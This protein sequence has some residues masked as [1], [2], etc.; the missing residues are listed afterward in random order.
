M[1]KRLLAIAE[2][3]R[4]KNIFIKVVCPELAEQ[5]ALQGFQ[6]IAKEQNAFVFAYS[7]EL[8]AVLQQYSHSQF[9][10]ESKLRF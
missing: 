3:E 8:I 7:D 6:Y 2:E 1:K 4:M 5:L 10:C 9:V